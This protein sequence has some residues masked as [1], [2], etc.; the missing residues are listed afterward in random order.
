MDIV[1][2]LEDIS[3]NELT[4]EDVFDEIIEDHYEKFKYLHAFLR[5]VDMKVFKKVKF[6]NC[7]TSDYSIIVELVSTAKDLNKLQVKLKEVLENFFYYRQENF[8]LDIYPASYSKDI[9]LIDICTI[10]ECR[11]DDIIYAN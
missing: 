6:C 11:E 5:S 10:N 8:R 9:L 3:I 7:K 2:L 4:S 1:N